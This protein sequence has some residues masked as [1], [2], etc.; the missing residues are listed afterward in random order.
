MLMILDKIR[1]LG[2]LVACGDGRFDGVFLAR[3]GS[4]E[5]LES[6]GRSVAGYMTEGFD[7]RQKRVRLT[8]LSLSI[9]RTDNG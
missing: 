8:T 1:G 3:A 5:C 9:C 6:L 2:A 4:I 7:G